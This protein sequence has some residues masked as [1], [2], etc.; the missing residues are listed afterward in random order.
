M[1]TCVLDEVTSANLVH[2]RQDINF[3]LGDGGSHDHIVC[4]TVHYGMAPGMMLYVIVG[5]N[6][7]KRTGDGL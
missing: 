5:R 6:K 4:Q 1:A 2:P 7:G 3:Y